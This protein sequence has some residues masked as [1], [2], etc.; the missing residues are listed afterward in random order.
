MRRFDPADVLEAGVLVLVFAASAYAKRPLFQL[1]ADAYD[2]SRGSVAAGLHEATRHWFRPL[3]AL[4]VLKLASALLL[5]TCFAVLPL[6]VGAFGA[7]WRSSNNLAAPATMG[8]FVLATV[9]G[10]FL[11]LVMIAAIVIYIFGTYAIVIAVGTCVFEQPRGFWSIG[12][13]LRATFAA[14]STGRSFTGGLALVIV[15]MSIAALI[16]GA[17]ALATH[18]N[19]DLR[20]FA[21]SVLDAIS[22]GFFATFAFVVYVDYRVRAEGLDLSARVNGGPKGAAVLVTST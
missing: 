14:G 1:L 9:A 20:Y 16:A 19:P 22:G 6:C 10:V 15:E 11:T 4:A 18:W 3:V 5:Y 17:A 2:G 8:A 21:V 13:G 12:K 7:I